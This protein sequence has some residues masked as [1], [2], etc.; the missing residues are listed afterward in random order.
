MKVSPLCIKMIAHH[1]GVRYKPYRCP[2]NLWTIGIG[3][4]MYPDHAKLTMADRLKVDLH[5][6]DNRVWSKEEV[7]AILA[8]DLAR[9]EN[10]PKVNLMLS[11]ALL[12]ILV[13]ERYSA[14]PSVKRCCAGIMKRLRLSL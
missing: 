6:E 2:A 1:E 12:S 11:S 9:F 13:W 8:S 7:D 10:L 14:A 3:H 5:P 4:V